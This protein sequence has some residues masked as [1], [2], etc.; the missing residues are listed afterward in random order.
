MVQ[1]SL[2]CRGLIPAAQQLVACV[3]VIGPASDCEACGQ[4]SAESE[5]EKRLQNTLAE[6]RADCRSV[7]EHFHVMVLGR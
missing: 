6:G 1:H 5:R 3:T 4:V 7:L 2:I